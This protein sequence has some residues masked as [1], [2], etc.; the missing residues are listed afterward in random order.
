MKSSKT[1]LIALAA[2]SGCL[3]NYNSWASCTISGPIDRLITANIPGEITIDGSVPTGSF[4]YFTIPYMTHSEADT[5]INCPGVNPTINLESEYPIA[6]SLNGHNIYDSSI[7]G[8]GFIIHYVNSLQGSLGGPAGNL[9]FSITPF[10]GTPDT[11]S[12][13]GD[14]RYSINLIKTGEIYTD[15]QLPA[16][17]ILVRGNIVSE[18][19]INVLN[20]RLA[21]PINIKI[22]RPTCS[23]NLPNFTVD[24]GEVSASDFNPSGRTTPK[25]FTIDL[26]CI[27]G[28]GTKNVHITLTD[29]N[30]P[31]NTSS[32][33]NLSPDSDA[34]GIALE[35]NNRLGA[36]TYGPD[37]NGTGNPGQWL[38][39][40]AGV[41]TYSIPLS[42]NYVRL[43]GP[44]KGGTANSGVTYTLN[45]D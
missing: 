24:L 11:I 22:L 5:T 9:P 41:G 39:G 6:G 25:D 31:G 35:V 18:G 28:S 4:L 36:V 37:L 34:Q 16:N 15:G 38:D 3:F 1:L 2:I 33:L 27:G 26:T 42:V 10:P 7:P 44:I 29:A 17:N 12:T 14:A 45:Y 40:A 30:Y 43:P 8:I 32:Q 13:G 23:V 20:S 21:S 19:N